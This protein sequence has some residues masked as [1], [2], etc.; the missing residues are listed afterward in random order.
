MQEPCGA[1]ADHALV[2]LGEELAGGFVVGDV[3][4]EG[5]VDA[6]PVDAADDFAVVDAAG[7]ADGF[8]AAETAFY[9]VAEVFYAEQLD[10]V[11]LLIGEKI[12]DPFGGDGF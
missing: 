11:I 6:G 10:G 3:G 8:V 1:E 2:G 12:H 4:F 5:A 7:G 9:A